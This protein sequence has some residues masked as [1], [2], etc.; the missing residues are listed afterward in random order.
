MKKQAKQTHKVRDE[1]GFLQ[2]LIHNPHPQQTRQFLTRL[3]HRDQYRVLQEL[4]VND[5]AH[6]IPLYD[7]PKKKK[8]LSEENRIRIKT[9]AQG[10]L[11]PQ[12]LHHLLPLIQIWARHSL[13]YYGLR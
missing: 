13:A 4:A 6:N 11:K 2:F 8:Q 12:H 7:Y 9:L 1:Q 10:K 5:L 3:L